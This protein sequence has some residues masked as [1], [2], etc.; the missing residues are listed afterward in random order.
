MMV[1]GDEVHAG[2]TEHLPKSL[3]SDRHRAGGGSAAGCGLRERSGHR[4][5]EADVAL[6]LLHYLV[7]VPVEHG[8]RAEASQ[9]RE[10]LRAVLGPPAPFGVNGP[11]RNVREDD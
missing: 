7:N 4:R 3:G 9:Y 11:Q 5:M 2:D 8:D 6:D 10:S 1:A